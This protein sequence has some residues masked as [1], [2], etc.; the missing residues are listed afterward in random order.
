AKQRCAGLPISILLQ[1]YRAITGTFD[2]IV[3]IGMI[4][5]VGHKNYR[6][7]FDIV[8]RALQEQGLFFL[9]TIGGNKTVYKTD[10]WL[11]KYIFPD[12]MIPSIRQL[13]NATE[14]LLRLEDWHNLGLDYAHTLRAWHKN[15]IAHW[16]T[17]RE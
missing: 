3:S 14:Q 13:G 10:P 11:H 12:S 4:E 7:Y 8:Q 17:L 6:R 5:H 1:D 9:Q 16:E 15:F 2:R